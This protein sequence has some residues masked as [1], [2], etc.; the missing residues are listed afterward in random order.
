MKFIQQMWLAVFLGIIAG[1]IAYA[2][3]IMAGLS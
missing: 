1:A 3:S 2:L